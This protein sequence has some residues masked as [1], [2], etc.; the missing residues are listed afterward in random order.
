MLRLRCRRGG[1]LVRSSVR[2]TRRAVH[3]R[4]VGVPDDIES[5][6]LPEVDPASAA[7]ERKNGNQGRAIVASIVRPNWMQALS[8]IA[9]H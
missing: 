7:R 3:V 4:A 5:G 8:A 6:E 2:P 1:A 9:Q